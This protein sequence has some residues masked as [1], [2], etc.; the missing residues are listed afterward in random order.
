MYED[1][2]KTGLGDRID[3]ARDSVF[4]RCRGERSKSGINGCTVEWIAILW[5]RTPALAG[6]SIF[7]R[8]LTNFEFWH[9]G[10]L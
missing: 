10:S 2:G 9:R 8:P 5:G 3:S 4:D 7:H 1:E 6:R